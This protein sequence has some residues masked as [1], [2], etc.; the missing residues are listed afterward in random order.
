[1]G[2]G[3]NRLH[4][5]DGES[6]SSEQSEWNMF[7]KPWLSTLC[8]KIDPAPR[9]QEGVSTFGLVAAKPAFNTSPLLCIVATGQVASPENMSQFIPITLWMRRTASSPQ[10]HALACSGSVMRVSG[11]WPWFG[12]KNKKPQKQKWHE[13]ENECS[14]VT[15]ILWS[16]WPVLLKCY[17]FLLLHSTSVLLRMPFSCFCCFL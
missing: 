9:R 12:R 15:W 1:M 16:G 2:D 10:T 5:D 6:N 17:Q 3:W 4:K 8:S 11:I 7:T 13:H 14:N